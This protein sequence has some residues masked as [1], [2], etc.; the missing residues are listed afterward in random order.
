MGT[1]IVVRRN[2]FFFTLVEYSL[3]IISQ[4]LFMEFLLSSYFFELSG[5]WCAFHKFD[6]DVIQRRQDLMK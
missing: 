6:E 4:V 5:Q 3:F 2:D 1:S